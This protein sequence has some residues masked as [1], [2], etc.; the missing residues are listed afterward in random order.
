MAD[1]STKVR[2]GGRPRSEKT[3]DAILD[4]AMEL[5][6]DRGLAAMSMDAVA[7]TAGVSK[8]TIYRWWPRKE[9]LAMDALYRQWASTPPAPDTETLREDLRN[10]F[11]PWTRQITR[12]PYARIIAGLLVEVLT[13]PEFALEYRTRFVEHL[14]DQGRLILQRAIGRREIS[15]HTHTEVVLDLLYG[16]IYHRMFHGHAPLDS[17]FI[18]QAIDTVLDGIRSRSDDAAAAGPSV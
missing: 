8:A 4:S 2:R 5:L 9:N 16:S 13:T 12:R 1:E 14:R 6:L 17:T 3:H 18:D 7:T 15:P 10:L 11:W